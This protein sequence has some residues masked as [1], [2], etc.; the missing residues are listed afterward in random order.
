MG[1]SEEMKET[2]RRGGHCGSDIQSETL[3]FPTGGMGKAC[4]LFSVCVCLTSFSGGAGSAAARPPV[5]V[6]SAP[7]SRSSCTQDEKHPF[8]CLLLFDY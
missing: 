2:Q 7:V 3:L 6:L 5:S 8:S 1:L 4:P